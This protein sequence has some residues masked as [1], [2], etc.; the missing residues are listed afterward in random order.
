VD[1]VLLATT[2]VFDGGLG[3]VGFA[4]IVEAD[5]EMAIVLGFCTETC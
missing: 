3:S 4:G 1:G 5:E 2:V